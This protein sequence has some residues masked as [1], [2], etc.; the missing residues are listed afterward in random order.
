VEQRQDAQDR[1]GAVRIGQVLEPGAHLEGVR[2][3]V[4]VAQHG[5]LG[6]AGRAAG[7]LQHSQVATTERDVDRPRGIGGQQARQAVCA[8]VGRQAHAMA[9]L[10]LLG[11]GEQHPE[12]D[13]E[14]VLDVGDDD[15]AHTGQL[16]QHGLQARE[17]HR[18]ADDHARLGVGQ[19]VLELGLDVQRAGRDQR[20][21]R[22]QAAVVGEH[23][24]RTVRHQKRHAVAFADAEPAQGVGE[25]IGGAVQLA[26]ADRAAEEAQGGAVRDTRRRGGQQ[27]WQGLIGHIDLEGDAGIVGG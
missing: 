20:R 7:V 8:A 25:A 26:V 22:A 4:A 13:R 5:C 27:G 2:Q 23:H 3:Q 16:R 14:V 1:V 21:A 12:P 6:H 9:V 10:A 15:V 11:Q 17:E 19:L 18:Q 24:L